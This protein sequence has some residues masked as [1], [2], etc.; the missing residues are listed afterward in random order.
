MKKKIANKQLPFNT[1]PL[2]AY[3]E[4]RTIHRHPYAVR[5]L[6]KRYGCS[7]HRAYLLA[8]LAGFWVEV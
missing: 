3:A 6:M 4:R 2:G 5:R 8:S 1:T 7:H